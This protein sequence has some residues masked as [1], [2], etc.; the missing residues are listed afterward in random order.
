MTYEK[1]SRAIRFVER[2]PFTSI[3]TAV[4]NLHTHN[5][6]KNWSGIFRRN[7]SQTPVSVVARMH[8]PGRASSTFLHHFRMFPQISRFCKIPGYIKDAPKDG[9]YPKKLCYAFGDNTTGWQPQA[10]AFVQKLY[11]F[12]SRRFSLFS[13][14][15]DT[16]CTQKNSNC[17]RLT[18]DENPVLTLMF[19]IL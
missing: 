15:T 4:S 18:S 9:S 6:P 16:S 2:Q 13:N 12:S 3:R 1:M 7:K 8:Q 17:L 10:G 11:I 19:S 5:A 14:E